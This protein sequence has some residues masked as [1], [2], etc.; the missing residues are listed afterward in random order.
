M[1]RCNPSGCTVLS[2][3]GKLLLPAAR[4]TLRTG[5]TVSFGEHIAL[6]N[7]QGFVSGGQALT[8][9]EIEKAALFTRTAD[10]TIHKKGQH[11]PWKVVMHGRIANYPIFQALL[12]EAIKGTPAAA[13]LEDEAWQRSHA[14]DGQPV[15]NIGTVSS[16]IGTDATSA[17]GRLHHARDPAGGP[18]GDHPGSTAK[19]W[20]GIK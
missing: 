16:A 5:G 8:W 18:R 14:A 4:E 12:H 2:E 6:L 3:T 9:T 20:T 13:L 15:A 19:T 11:V 17:D 7:S 1:R 10:I